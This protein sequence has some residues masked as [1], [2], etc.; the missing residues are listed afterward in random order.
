MNWYLRETSSGQFIIA[1]EKTGKTIGII[2]DKED[3]LD[4][5]QL[6][7]QVATF[8][9][10]L[11]NHICGFYKLKDGSCP[12]CDWVY[13]SPNSTNKLDNT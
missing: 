7:E 9:V 12:V 10:T 1:N 8:D 3:A 13:E 6:L 2:Y 11:G 5:M 4:L